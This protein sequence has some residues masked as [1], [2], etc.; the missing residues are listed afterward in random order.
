MPILILFSGI[1]FT[2]EL[3]TNNCLHF[4]HVLIEERTIGFITSTYRKHTHTGFYSKWSS[5]VPLHRK[6]NLVNS[7]LRRAYDIASSNQLVHTEFMNIKRMLSRHGNPNIFL[8]LCIQQFLNR[9]YGVT[10]QRDTPAEPS[11]SPKYISLQLPYLGS[12]CNNIRQEL[13]SFIR[14]KAVVNAKLRCF[15]SNRKLES[16]F[17]IK[18]WQA[19]LNRINVVYKL[20]CSCDASYIGQTQRNLINHIEEHR[21][22]LSSS[23][24][25]HFQANPDHRVDFH[26]PEVIGSD[27]NWRRLQILES[28]LIQEHKPELNANIPSM[29]L[30][31]FNV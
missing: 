22:S 4:L 14:H 12:V 1:V 15:Q 29:P 2:K 26:N 6:R 19:L 7:L 28:L 21:T 20:T 24:C 25:R 8:D 16:W 3:E 31:I 30:C 17:S 10:Q 9:K 27:N 23:V 5:F 11:P 13:S 18:D